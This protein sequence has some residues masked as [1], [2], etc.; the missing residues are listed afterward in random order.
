M[1]AQLGED[2]SLELR[3][4]ED[5]LEHE[6][7]VREVL[8]AGRG[9]D[10]RAEEAR[11]ALVV[12]ALRD[13]LLE[14]VLDAVARAREGVLADVAHGDR[15]FQAAEE[16]R[17]E[18]RGHQPRSDDSDL[19]D[20]ARFGFRAAG[21]SL[22]APVDEVE[23]VEGGLRLAAGEQLADRLL[24]GA[25]ALLE[26]P[27]G[28]GALDQLERL[29]RSGRGP[30]ELVVEPS[31]RLPYHFLR[32]VA[33]TAT[34]TVRGE[35]G[36]EGDR[37]VQE[38]GRL[39]QAVGEAEFVGLWAGQHPVLAHRVRDDELHRRLD[40]DQARHELGSAPG[41]N[42]PEEAFGAAEMPD[43]SRDRARLAVQRDLD[44]TAEAGAH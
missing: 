22:R 35:L 8:V 5:G 15:D 11:L 20:R 28:A 19:P 9:R 31:A 12:P 25:V 36:G 39:D 14:L 23:G 18:L 29:V 17:R 43:R 37:L 42:D 3:L 34:V 13:L 10:E 33:V 1:L 30:V 41:G 32:R 27:A 21:W 26:R 16:E 2:L 24:L 40:A 7:A 38:L 6:V 4:L 44:T